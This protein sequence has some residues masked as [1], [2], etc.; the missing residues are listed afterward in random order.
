MLKRVCGAVILVW[1][2]S[3]LA[4]SAA[5][6]TKPP[7]VTVTLSS[8]LPSPELVGTSITWT[9]TIQGGQQGHTYDYQFSAALQGQ[10]QIV[11]DFNLPNTFT[12]V[13]WQVEGTYVVTVV[14][15]DITSQPYT[16]Y[17]PVSAQYQI[18]PYVTASGGSAVNAT[19]HPLVALF[20]AGPCTTGH[21]IRVRFHQNGSQTL[22]STNAV[23]C[24]SKSANF[25]VAG[26]IP[27][28]QYQMHWEEFGNNYDQ[29]GS[30]QSF[31]TG[32]LP[33]N[34]GEQFTVKVPASQHDALYP[35]VL[36]QILPGSQG[37]FTF[38]S[39]AADLSGNITWYAPAQALFTRMEP[40]GNY[41]TITNTLLTE[42]DLAGNTTLQTNASIINEQLA[43]KHYPQI[44][45][46]NQ[47]ETRRLPNGNILL[48]G[49]R[50]VASP[51]Y[52]GGSP[53][54]PVDIIGDVILI[55]DHNMQL[56]WAWDS[57]A[58]QDLNRKATLGETCVHNAP[59][60]PLFNNNYLIANDWLH[61]NSVQLMEDGNILLSER[62]QDWLL[63]INYGNG[64]GD[65]H[66]MW[67]MGP[68][69]DFTITNPSQHPC[70]DPN[71]Y[72]WFSHQHDA[73]FQL[74]NGITK[75]L[76][77]YDDGNLRIH[78]C[79][80]GDS[81][82]MVISVA[83]V[84]HTV[85]MQTSADM[86]AFSPALGS[87]QILPS[88]LYPTYASFDSGLLNIGGNASQSTETDLSGNIVYQ[89]QANWTS[90]R[91]YRMQDLYT[92]PVP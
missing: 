14:A 71:I 43:A 63:K 28:T 62:H 67:R 34:L 5:A 61:S 37:V 30:D 10:T 22:T 15:R 40:G 80:S 32:P 53:A 38:L 82:G 68:Y 85:Y 3:L 73:S 29:N 27:S 57:F 39:T 4:L 13:P 8:S 11:R 46:F 76:T 69:G 64:A 65:G 54:H 56:V 87:A 7:Q 79:G 9:A 92:E 89:L 42:Y 83:E 25:L 20:S 45:C 49:S 90:Y 12:W 6:A 81:R 84:P 19:S 23:P 24:S 44:T 21:S 16:V 55:L 72:S 41:F 47:H 31:T 77:V 2:L 33:P 48:L 52:Q 51:I 91:I 66:I 50:D 86:E 88:T 36:F 1:V 26:M 17:P 58:H 59:G 74:Q 70:G 18:N 35:Y 75:I 60:C 78:S